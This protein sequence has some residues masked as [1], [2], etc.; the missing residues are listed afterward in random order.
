MNRQFQKTRTLLSSDE[1]KLRASMPSRQSAR[2]NHFASPQSTRKIKASPRYAPGATGS[3][4]AI[5]PTPCKAA[6][7]Y[8]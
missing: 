4:I 5:S 8:S 7:T 3:R 2:A 6:A 1:P